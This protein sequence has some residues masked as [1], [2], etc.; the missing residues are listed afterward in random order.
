MR[1]AA[2]LAR[3]EPARLKA[4]LRSLLR[5][6]EGEA[7][8]S[9]AR[10]LTTA[11]LLAAS[12]G[13]GLRRTLPA[14]E[15][16]R[17]HPHYRWLSWN[18]DEYEAFRVACVEA[19]VIFDVGANVG[20]YSVLFGLWARVS[21]G[22]VFAFEPS[23]QI[24][25]WLKRHI[26]LNHLESIITPLQLAVAA[27]SGTSGWSAGES[28]GAGHITPEV[29][30]TNLSEV[31]Q[32]VSLDEFCTDKA[33][34]PD[35]VKIDVEG[36]EFEVLEGATQLLQARPGRSFPTVFV[37]LHPT[38]WIQRGRTRDQW[39]TLLDRLD[40]RMVPL[41]PSTDIWAV[42]GVC[43]RLVPKCSKGSNR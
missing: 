12:F 41:N 2:V 7:F 32:T 15:V 23:P 33:L 22:R 17:V 31:V 8:P 34:A 42:E 4:F 9:W 16:F 28:E 35:V 36:F 20:A 37:E 5:L 10:S 27:H 1:Q 30:G 21:G 13:R 18:F 26:R 43:V 25:G 24:F 40:L 39:V 6:R 14:G 29:S 3:S 11:L 19:K 38:A